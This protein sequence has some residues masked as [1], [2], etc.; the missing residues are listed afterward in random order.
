MLKFSIQTP[1][2]ASMTNVWKQFDQN[3]LEKL[4]PPF[5]IVRISTFEGCHT[6]DRVVLEMDFLL[7]KTTWSSII[8]DFQESESEN[9]FIDEGVKMPFGLTYWQHK[10][11]VKKLTDASSAVVDTIQFKSKFFLLDYLLYPLFYGM[12]L[13]RIPIYQKL[14]STKHEI[15]FN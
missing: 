14:L 15:K 2:K 12:I 1:I 8:T 7:L 10:H 5:P 3:L 9:F 6:N 4:S 11:S 13:Y